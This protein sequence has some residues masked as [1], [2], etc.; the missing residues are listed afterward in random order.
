MINVRYDPSGV[1]LLLVPM[2]RTGVG[3]DIEGFCRSVSREVERNLFLRIEVGGCMLD[4]VSKL[5]GC[6]HYR[7]YS[8]YFRNYLVEEKIKVSFDNV[9]TMVKM[10][11]RN[12]L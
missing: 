7:G 8:F 1:H 11:M 6:R 9:F 4:V 3:P 5:M 12:E 2:L 10:R